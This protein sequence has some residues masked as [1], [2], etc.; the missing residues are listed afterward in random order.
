MK[1]F[2]Q[3]QRNILVILIFICIIGSLLYFVI[4][5]LLLR[6]K[7]VQDQIQEEE[8]KQ[9]IQQQ[10]LNNLPK[11]QEQ[12]K[13]LQKNKQMVDVLFDKNNAVVLIEKL[14]KLAQDSGNVIKISVQEPQ[15]Q[16]TIPTATKNKTAIPVEKTL[17]EKLPSQDYLQMKIELSG[18]YNTVV[19]FINRLENFEYYCDI[20]AIQIGQEKNNSNSFS[21]SGTLNYF[22][23]NSKEEAEK[24]AALNKEN[25]IA[26]LDIVFY[27]KK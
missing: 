24:R 3:K 18:K 15:Q 12:Y 19:D 6:I 22:E 11:M 10:Q 17:V 23:P 25:I 9:E 21:N 1:K 5:P 13:F 2:F 7:N 16:K 27:T 26:G 20:I 14:E 4:F 8:L